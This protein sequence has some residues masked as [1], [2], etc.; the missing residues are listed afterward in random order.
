MLVN[1]TCIS[2]F[3]EEA[4][5]QIQACTIFLRTVSEAVLG[6]TRISLEM[7]VERYSLSQGR[8]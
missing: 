2:L 7:F 3:F 1:R 8:T 4:R 5:I 6:D